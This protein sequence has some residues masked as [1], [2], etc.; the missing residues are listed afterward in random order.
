MV[1]DVAVEAQSERLA[2]W[3][4]H[5]LARGSISLGMVLHSQCEQEP[6]D[7][8]AIP[9]SVEAQVLVI[10]AVVDIGSS[11]EPLLQLPC[12]C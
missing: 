6:K 3:N 2:T 1:Q 12:L 11:L 10:S 9:M 4:M 5:P 8:W 7:G